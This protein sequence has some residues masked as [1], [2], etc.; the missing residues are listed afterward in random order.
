MSAGTGLWNALHGAADNRE[1]LARLSALLRRIMAEELTDRQREAFL[2][3]VGQGLR[4]K[5][6]AALWRVHP[7]VVCRH[8]QRAEEQLRRWI[9][10]LE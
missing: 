2:L 6:I 3:H 9:S 1:R 5:E 4:Q 7:S 10:K 8:L